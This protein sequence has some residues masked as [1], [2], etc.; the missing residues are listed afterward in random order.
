MERALVVVEPTETAKEL[1]YEAG[2]I[3]EGVGAD[4]ILTHITTE[5][6]YGARRDA[7]ESL[8]SSSAS[9]TVGEAEEG[10]TQFARDIGDEVL[11]EL[12]VEYEVTGFLG[13][14]AE[15][16][17]DAADE[18]DCDHVFLTGRQ[19]SPTGK[20]L[21]GDATQGVILDFEGPVTVLT[22]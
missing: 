19:R 16:I 1:A 8:M 13:N 2:T 12:D 20:A 11:S 18:Y 5:Q 17:L 7:M 3:A 4:M 15:K 9:Y 10:A 22:D 14:K 21:F 6:E